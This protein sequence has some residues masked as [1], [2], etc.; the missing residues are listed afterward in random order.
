MIEPMHSISLRCVAKVTGR[1]GTVRS[2][3]SNSFRRVNSDVSRSKPY[4]AVVIKSRKSLELRSVILSILIELLFLADDGEPSMG[5]R[6]MISRHVTGG[7]HTKEGDRVVYPESP[8]RVR[9][10]PK[11]RNVIYNE[12]EPLCGGAHTAENNCNSSCPDTEAPQQWQ[13]PLYYEVCS[14]W[15]RYSPES[16]RHHRAFYDRLLALGL[17]CR[18]AGPLYRLVLPPRLVSA[19]SA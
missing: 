19:V 11:R 18:L 5:V 14:L 4:E 17:P 7:A 16:L 6:G 10:A 1:S 9:G 8:A 12:P 2:D 15:S 13:R 3:I